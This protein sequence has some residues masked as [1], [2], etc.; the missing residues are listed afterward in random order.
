[1]IGAA[2]VLVML[3]IAGLYLCVGGA[4][5]LK[6]RR[7]IAAGS[8]GLSGIALLACTVAIGAIG[9][10]IHT[11]SRL[12]YEHDVAELTFTKLATQ[13]Y[14]VAVALVDRDQILSYSLEGDEW[15]IDARVLKFHGIANLLGLDARYRLDRLSGRYHDL[16][17]E[18][19]RARSV[20]S[21]ADWQAGI[22]VWS[23]ARSQALP[24]VDAHYGNATYLPMQD[25]ARFG[26]ALTQ[27]GLV[28]RPLNTAGKEALERW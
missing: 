2:V 17:Q 20:Y 22:D 13:H 23:L 1:M 26:V 21:L 16:E 11:Y 28:A 5:K 4:I 6:Q 7:L 9:L 18:R 25:R 27:S 8:R 10:S 3:A 15:Q 12:T 14:Q 24:W 19:T